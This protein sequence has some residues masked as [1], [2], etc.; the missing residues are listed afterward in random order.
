MGLKSIG[1]TIPATFPIRPYSP[2]EIAES[3]Q[4]LDDSFDG[5]WTGDHLILGC[6]IVDPIVTLSSLA[7]VTKRVRLCTGILHL[8]IR[9]PVQTA[10]A[11]SSLDFLSGGR[12]TVGVGVGGEMTAEFEATGTPVAERGARSDEAITAMRALFS[13]TP[14]TFDGR[15]ASFHDVLFQPSCVQAGG[16][17]IWVGGRT[18]R[19]LRRAATLGDG[20]LG[21][22]VTPEGFKRR[23][24]QLEELM[25]GAPRPDFAFA[26]HLPACVG[27]GQEPHDRLLSF[28]RGIY[29]QDPSDFSR[30]WLAGTE[31]QLIEQVA[32]Y[33]AAGVEHVVL[34]PP[35]PNFIQQLSDLAQL[36]DMLRR[37]L[38]P[39]TVHAP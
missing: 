4:I 13:A 28:Y 25:V 21:L 37:E 26:L 10:K 8:P 15:F 35:G 27:S 19:A 29:P 38:A 6:G 34:A 20:W 2:T 36:A 16:P 9:P 39:T 33:V 12:L 30:F 18:D 32:G 31:D 17:P 22:F 7:L 11:L 5:A 14:A 24:D 23:R 1:A 3:A